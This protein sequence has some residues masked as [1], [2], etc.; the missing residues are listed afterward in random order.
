MRATVIT[1][2]RETSVLDVPEP[3]VG[4]GTAVVGIGLTG[5]CGTDVSAWKSGRPYPPFLSGHEWFGTV[6]EVGHEQADLAPG[7]RAVMGVPTA[8]GRCGPCRAGVWHRCT[9][10]FAVFAGA[11]H[12]GYAPRIAVPV[13]SL[14]KVPP[15]LTAE[16]AA[17]VEPATVALH[18]V[19]RRSPRLGDVV[20]V[21]GAGPIGLC[22]LQ[23]ARLAGAERVILAEPREARRELGERLGA[24]AAVEP[25]PALDDAVRD[26]T[27]G[28][29]A[30]L[31]YDCAG[32]S[33]SINAAIG[34]AR[35][36][37]V[38]MMVGVSP[39]DITISPGA[40]LAKEL[41]IDTSLAHHHH[42]FELTMRLVADGR[43]QLAPLHART[44]PLTELD[45]ALA[46]LAGG[47]DDAKILVDPAGSGA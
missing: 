4:A 14:V 25:G 38:V 12:G 3:Q 40:W 16:E 24:D 31:V 39:E 10:A 18:A 43:I 7:D 35:P 44:V 29:G 19:R 21:L 15:S 9:A 28:L 17:Q 34:L 13:G 33:A 36:G 47:S 41:V 8:C 26:L 45:V 2:R 27:R 32:S 42:E 23:Y 30:D 1:G 6:L 46:D 37:G 11:R 20:V 22:T 5:I